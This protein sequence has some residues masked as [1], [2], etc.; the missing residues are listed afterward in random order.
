MIA[1]FAVY[2]E[3]ADYGLHNTFS[4]STLINK[5]ILLVAFVP[6]EFL[7]NY[8]FMALRHRRKYCFLL[9]GIQMVLTFHLA[10]LS[11]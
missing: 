3:A 7:L 10:S 5:A 9:L 6:P 8:W 4:I 1:M 2:P 11:V